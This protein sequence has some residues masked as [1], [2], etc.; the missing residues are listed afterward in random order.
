MIN[1]AKATRAELESNKDPEKVHECLAET[2]GFD[3]LFNGFS[4]V[5]FQLKFV[6][7]IS[8]IARL[9]NLERKH[10]SICHLNVIHADFL[11]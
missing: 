1:V 8:Q 11:G 9:I 2:L 7:S 10:F 3:D 6:E 5:L 4:N